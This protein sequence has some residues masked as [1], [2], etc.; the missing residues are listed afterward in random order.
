MTPF[1]IQDAL[2]SPGCTRAEMKTP[3]LDLAFSLLG[4]LSFEVIVMYSHRLPARVLHSVLRLTKLAENL[5]L[6]MRDR[7]S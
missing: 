4:S 2:L 1:I 7:S 6:S 3:F 5:S